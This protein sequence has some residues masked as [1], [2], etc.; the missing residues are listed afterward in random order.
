M[1]ARPADD[2]AVMRELVAAESAFREAIRRRPVWYHTYNELRVVY[3]WTAGRLG[4]KEE[5]FAA[6]SASM[7]AAQIA[8]WLA[9]EL[10]HKGLLEAR[11]A[12]AQALIAGNDRKSNEAALGLM[13][14]AVVVADSLVQREPDDP[15]Y[16]FS[17]AEAKCGMGMVRRNLG[18]G[19]WENAI[20]SGLIDVQRAATLAPDR[21]KFRTKQASWRQYLGEELAKSEGEKERARAEFALALQGYEEAARLDPKN[22]E[23]QE[24]IREVRAL[25]GG[26][27]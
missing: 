14:E 12:F 15:D 26:G 23:A 11:N 4:R 6:L 24:G 5:R 10:T 9:P 20:R 13:Q 16:R 8:A 25:M 2:A 1:M 3:E 22:A 21:I 17:L 19:G 27:R 18:V 7:H